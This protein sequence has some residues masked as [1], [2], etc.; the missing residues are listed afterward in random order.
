M[1]STDHSHGNAEQ[2]RV[3]RASCAAENYAAG[4]TRKDGLAVCH[5]QAGELSSDVLR[6]QEFS[7]KAHMKASGRQSQSHMRDCRAESESASG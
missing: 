5:V 3:E 2:N 6:L 4:R 1:K 7:G